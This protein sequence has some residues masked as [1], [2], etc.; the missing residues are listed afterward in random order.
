MQSVSYRCGRYSQTLSPITSATSRDQKGDQL[1]FNECF[2]VH[3]TEGLSNH[4]GHKTTPGKAQN[5]LESFVKC[6][7]VEA[8]RFKNMTS[9]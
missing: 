5:S 6:I 1:D 2:Q 7:C 4:Q 9:G 3:G 8:K